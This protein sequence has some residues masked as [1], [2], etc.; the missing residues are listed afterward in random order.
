MSLPARRYTL[1][2]SVPD[3]RDH[4]YLPIPHA[5]A[6]SPDSPPVTPVIPATPPKSVD[7][8][9]LMPAPLDQGQVG[10]CAVN[11]TA[12]ALR[13]LLNKEHAVV[14]APSRLFMYWYVRRLMNVPPTED[15]GSDLRTL[16]KAVQQYHVPDEIAWPYGPLPEER[17]KLVPSADA[18]A[19][20]LKHVRLKYLAVNQSVTDFQ[21]CLSQGYPIVIGIVVYPEFESQ[22]VAATGDVPMPDRTQQ[23]LG[24]H[25]VLMCGIDMQTQRVICQNSWGPAWGN[26]GFFTLPLAYVTDPT[27]AFDF[28]TYRTFL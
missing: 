18:I 2:R 8:R 12:N 24:G 3:G 26:H 15:S 16:C 27:L 14:F 25:A 21:A 13:Y 22:A 11:A 7:L 9:P 10:T 20:A 17:F 1:R 4:C 28:W 6:P 19:A 23:S 5:P